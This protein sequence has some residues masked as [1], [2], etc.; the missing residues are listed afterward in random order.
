MTA[1]D[2]RGVRALIDRH[3]TRVG[4][5]QA[6]SEIHAHLAD[7]AGCRRYYELR[8]AAERLDPAALGPK[9]RLRRTLGL[10]Q[11]RASRLALLVPALATAAVASVA[12]LV[13]WTPP[14][15]AQFRAR[16]GGESGNHLAVF[17]VSG[18]GNS[19][20]VGDSIQATDELAFAY[21]NP[22]GKARLLVFGV[23]DL[24]EVYWYYPAWRD[25]TANP[26]A[27]P[28]V[29]G[30][31][32]TELEASIR[33]GIRGRQLRLFAVFTDQPRTVREIEAL[34]PTDAVSRDRLPLPESHQES[35]LL[36][37]EPAEDA[38]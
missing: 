13:M 26:A 19:T 16:G 23:D 32:L 5:S 25:P 24:G 10:R 22:A 17:R 7:C 4:A 14:E 27:V 38:P 30:D 11:R 29:A 35:R 28:I 31:T 2:H 36:R 1:R 15:P 12:V 33:H 20:P 8:L 37:V 9:E 34:L 3:F 21:E 6:F 18:A